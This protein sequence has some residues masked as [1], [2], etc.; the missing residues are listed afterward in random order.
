[1]KAALADLGLEQKFAEYRAREAWDQAVGPALAAQSRPL[2]VRN[3]RMEVAVPSA[4]WRTQLNFLK[5]DI[6]ARLN[7]LTGDEGIKDLILMN[8]PHGGTKHE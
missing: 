3:G 6:V 8:Q 5:R 1:M 2:R 7:E 4:V